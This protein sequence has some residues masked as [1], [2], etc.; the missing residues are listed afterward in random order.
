MALPANFSVILLTEHEIKLQ[1]NGPWDRH[2]T[3][4][5]DIEG[6]VETLCKEYGPDLGGRRLS[7]LD[8]DGDSTEVNVLN[9]EFNGFYL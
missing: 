3:I 7:Y 6:V 2:Y 8:S 1:D 9:G 4:T 5:N